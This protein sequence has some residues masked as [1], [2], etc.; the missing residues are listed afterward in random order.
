[1]GGPRGE[2]AVPFPGPL[3][4]VHFEPGQDRRE[5]REKSGSGQRGRD[6]VSAS[7]LS[8][9][10]P[11]WAPR[12]PEPS[13]MTGTT[14]ESRG[15]G[16]CQS[17]HPGAW[18]VLAADRAFGE[19]LPI[20]FLRW[21]P[22]SLRPPKTTGHSS[23][24]LVWLEG[25]VAVSDHLAKSHFCPPSWSHVPARRSTYSLLFSSLFPAA[26]S[27]PCFTSRKTLLSFPLAAPSTNFLFRG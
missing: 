12:P 19:S 22:G 7:L 3:S 6:R 5:W 1:M 27:F 8:P 13:Q 4:W 17:L 24:S 16:W 25:F 14:C 26:G 15:W 11:S 18:H 9:A 20:I 21:S 2:G 23:R 10:S